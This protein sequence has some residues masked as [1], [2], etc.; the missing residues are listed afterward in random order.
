[1]ASLAGM[2]FSFNFSLDD[3]QVGFSGYNDGLSKFIVEV[4]KR[5]QNFEVDREFFEIKKALAIRAF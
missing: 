1:M 2:G 3:L 4:L 5:V